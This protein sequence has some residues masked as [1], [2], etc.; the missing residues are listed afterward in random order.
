ML[1]NLSTD[2]FCTKQ[3]HNRLFFETSALLDGKWPF[4][5]F[6]TSPLGIEKQRMMLILRSIGK[7]V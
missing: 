5:A 4:C 7:R 3:L 6:E 2:S 1:Y